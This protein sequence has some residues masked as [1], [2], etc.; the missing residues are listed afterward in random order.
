M[1]SVESIA[2]RFG[3]VQALNDVSLS[4]PAGRI[5]G[6]I[7]PN[8]AGKTTLFNV[9]SGLQRP[10][11]GRVLLEDRDV[12]KLDPFQRARLGLART[13]QRLEIFTSM[14]ARDNLLVAAEL[15]KSRTPSADPRVTTTDLLRRLH[16]ERVVDVQA[17]ILPTG[18]ARLVELGRALATQP[19]V[20]L[21]DEPGS[22][23][24]TAESEELGQVLVELAGSGMAVLLV[25]HD[26]D[27]VM[28]VSSNVFVLDGGQV[29]SVGDPATVQGDPAVRLAYLGTDTHHAARPGPPPVGS[30]P[31]APAQANGAYGSGSPAVTGPGGGPS[32]EVDGPPSGPAIQLKDVTA[33][34]GGIEV[35]H[36]VDLTVRG[37]TVFAILGPNGAGKST[38][39]KVIAGHLPATGGT[40]AVGK[41]DITGRN[42]ARLARTGLCCV[43]EGRAVFPNLTVAENLHMWTFRGSATT[44]RAVEEQAFAR[45]PI[46]GSRRNQL[47]GTLSGGEQQMLAMS[48]ALT[49][50]PRV[51]LLDEISMGLAPKIVAELYEVVA[52]LAQSGLTILLVEQFAPTALGIADEAAIMRNGRITMTGP[53]DA[54]AELLADA[55]LGA[56]SAT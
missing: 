52:G 55:Y 12:T 37:G 27:L 36:G 15:H 49:T 21:L 31:A 6:L 20:L 33:G 28:S 4:A 47:A 29:I 45:F 17:G 10:T 35:L 44:R 3:G 48:R 9:I 34:Y 53:P 56:A 51:L 50:N 54:V 8:G 46:L 13:F 2:V 24:S 39:L 16:L 11:H 25:E 22:G 30:E 43:P 5:T 41:D 42:A 40:V 18:L 26:I 14:T 32:L 7:G 23:L 1:L 38:L 19:K